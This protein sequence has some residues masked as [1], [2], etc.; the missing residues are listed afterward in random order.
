MQWM[1]EREQ[2]CMIGSMV[3][4]SASWHHPH[5]DFTERFHLPKSCSPLICATDLPRS[6][7][8]RRTWEAC[9]TTSLSNTLCLFSIVKFTR[10][11][12]ASLLRSHPLQQTTVLFFA[13]M[14]KISLS[15]WHQNNICDQIAAKKE[16]FMFTS[17]NHPLINLIKTRLIEP[18]LWDQM[19][20][21]CKRSFLLT[22]GC[23]SFKTLCSISIIKTTLHLY[24]DL[25]AFSSH[26]DVWLSCTCFI[27][28]LPE[29]VGEGTHFKIPWLQT[30]NIMDIRT[31]PRTI[32]SVTGTK[33]ALLP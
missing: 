22:W 11:Q 26:I 14:P 32:Q 28:V 25:N 13:S 29:A 1:V 16:N 6:N 12:N 3:K 10:L 5:H 9:C 18:V 7:I 31:R 4:F 23:R 27:G 30:P 33:G 24:V 17:Q 15:K 19:S 8:I 2:W 21:A 20:S